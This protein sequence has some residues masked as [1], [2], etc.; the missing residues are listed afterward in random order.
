MHV[1]LF[2]YFRIAVGY[3]LSRLQKV[4][5]F[6]KAV[7][8]IELMSMIMEVLCNA[9]FS[10]S[11]NLGTI[12]LRGSAHRFWV[13]AAPHRRDPSP[14]RNAS[15]GIVCV[16]L[17]FSIYLAIYLSCVVS[18]HC[19]WCQFLLQPAPF[20]LIH[21]DL[22]TKTYLFSGPGLAICNVVFSH[23]PDFRVCVTFS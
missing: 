23:S 5:C 8:L 11:R 21:G 13:T 7:R 3:F 2:M 15:S 20:V 16:S 12:L 6:E 22:E 9:N 4:K 1:K 14:T 17:P 10:S 19:C 18:C